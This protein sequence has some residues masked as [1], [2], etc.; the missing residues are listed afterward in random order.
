MLAQ[1]KILTGIPRSGTS[2]SCKL[3]NSLPDTVALVEPLSDNDLVSIGRESDIHDLVTRC[4]D[5]TRA[6]LHANGTA[7]SQNIRGNVTG[8][9]VAEK[10][11]S[12]KTL[13]AIV[14][15]SKRTIR[16]RSSRRSRIKVEKPL[17]PCFSLYIK[18]TIAFTTFLGS[19]TNSYSCYAQIRNPLATLASWNTVPFPIAEGRAFFAERHD[20]ALAERICRTKCRIDKQ[21]ELISWMFGKYSQYLAASQIIRYEDVVSSNGRTLAKVCPNADQLN[22]PLAC[23]NRSEIY[24]RALMRRIASRLLTYQGPIWDFYSRQDVIDLVDEAAN[25]AT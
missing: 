9:T 25:D 10:G 7:I 17:S 18:H 23:K 12:E 4:F 14:T 8:N 5:R 21:I 3:L 22:S 15:H 16:P 2:L 11:P 13:M 6:T 24:N 1:N 19:L 20:A